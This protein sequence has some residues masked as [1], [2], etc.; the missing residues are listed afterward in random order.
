M[1][2]TLWLHHPAP[3]P[4]EGAVRLLEARPTSL[5]QLSPLRHE[6]RAA[7][8]NE[9]RPPGMEDEAADRLLLACE[10]LASNGL[11][12]GRGEV[13]ATVTTLATGWLL[14]VS[15]AAVDRPPTPAIGRDPA[16]GGLGLFLVAGFS[17]ACGWS[18]DGPRKHVWARIDFTPAEETQPTRPWLPEPRGDAPDPERAE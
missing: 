6:L 2:K 9:S 5:A 16:F 11:R 8:R 17:S 7:L 10:E 18:V 1:S 12:H 3:L 14:D 4:G 15:D 13:R